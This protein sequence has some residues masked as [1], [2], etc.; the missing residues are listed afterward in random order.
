MVR[1]L[2]AQFVSDPECC[3]LSHCIAFDQFVI[4]GSSEAL[5][6][7][8]FENIGNAFNCKT[9]VYNFTVCW[10][11]NLV[12]LRFG[13]YDSAPSATNST[14]SPGYCTASGALKT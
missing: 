9:M 3:H 10:F 12:P 14:G 5:V 2:I 1:V 6:Y 8:P 4:S 7:S 11:E 13:R